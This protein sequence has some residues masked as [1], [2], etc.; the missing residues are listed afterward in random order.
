MRVCLS[1]AMTNCT[2]LRH[3][4][5]IRSI[6]VAGRDSGVTT[7]AGLTTRHKRRPPPGWSARCAPPWRHVL[8]AAGLGGPFGHPVHPLATLT[9]ALIAT[10]DAQAGP[11]T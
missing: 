3:R 5:P 8:R 4:K 2:I 9:R 11:R 10:L 6:F 7:D 1:P